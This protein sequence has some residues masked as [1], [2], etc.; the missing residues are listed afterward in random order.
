MARDISR[1]QAL[2]A[3]LE[4]LDSIDTQGH[5]D[6]KQYGKLKRALDTLTNCIEKY[7][8]D[9]LEE[10]PELTNENL[11]EINKA[12]CDAIKECRNYTSDKGDSRKSGYGQ[13]RLKT[14]RNI[15]QILDQDLYAIQTADAADNVTLPSLISKARALDANIET[16]M[17]D[18]S[19]VGANS[20]TRVPVLIQ[21]STGPVE[22]FFTEDYKL[23][24]P[25][26]MDK[27]LRKKYDLS[28]PAMETL[29]STH[30]VLG[31]FDEYNMELNLSVIQAIRDEI[32]KMSSQKNTFLRILMN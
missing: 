9:N 16:E 3:A 14:V 2:D 12:Y 5:R 32:K 13:A 17:K 10:A 31:G 8:P 7:Y 28:S 19:V 29:F 26:E 25:E 24:S 4:S 1:N 22:G 20:S 23:M 15:E 6:S 18:L 21:T 30:G 11:Q 27:T